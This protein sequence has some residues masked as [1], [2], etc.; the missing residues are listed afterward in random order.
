MDGQ[1]PYEPPGW[2]GG[3]AVTNLAGPC[4]YRATR[5]NPFVGNPLKG[6][7]PA[8]DIAVEVINRRPLRARWHP[9]EGP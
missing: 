5:G 7:G 9:A 4:A 2:V 6:R 8:R 3:D 1:L